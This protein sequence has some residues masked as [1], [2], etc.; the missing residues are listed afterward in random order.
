MRGLS[1]QVLTLRQLGQLSSPQLLAAWSGP[2]LTA[3]CP[4]TLHARQLWGSSAPLAQRTVTLLK[5]W[6]GPRNWTLQHA[7]LKSSKEK[8]RG[9]GRASSLEEE[10][11]EEEEEDPEASDYEDELQDD[12][13]LPEGF[14]DNER[15]IQSLRF[16][17]VLKAG[18]DIARHKVEDALYDNKLRLNGQKL[19]KKSKNV[20]VGDTLD[21]IVGEDRDLDTVI[22]KRV[23]LKKLVGE[24][25]DAS[26]HKVILR[27]WKH[28]HLPKRDA[29]SE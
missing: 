14:K 16:D 7:R 27:S 12:P 24:T 10:E 25:K 11:E 15:V 13:D 23:I 2:S 3:W 20:K 9:R 1:V 19:I 18:L 8:G 6:H 22:V 29:L 21:L 28:L 5:P 4:R 26:K 17:L